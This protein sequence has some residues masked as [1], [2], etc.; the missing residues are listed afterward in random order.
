[1]RGRLPVSHPNLGQ[2]VPTRLLRNLSRCPRSL[3]ERKLHVQDVYRSRSNGIVHVCVQPMGVTARAPRLIVDS[4]FLSGGAYLTL[5]LSLYSL[6]SQLCDTM[7]QGP[8]LAVSCGVDT[9]P[10]VPSCHSRTLPTRSRLCFARRLVCTLSGCGVRI[11]ALID[12]YLPLLGIIVRDR[13]QRCHR[14][15]VRSSGCDFYTCLCLRV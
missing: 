4:T 5:S 10:R 1:M 2:G 3:F 12:S 7:H 14:L 6:L 11:R 13:S 9:A 8:L 15:G